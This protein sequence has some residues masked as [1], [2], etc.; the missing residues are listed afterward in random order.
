MREG[1]ATIRECF[2]IRGIHD[3]EI[4]WKE[5][6]NQVNQRLYWFCSVLEIDQV[7]HH[8]Y[9]ARP[10]REEECDSP[11]VALRIESMKLN[12]YETS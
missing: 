2:K 8:F 10:D 3:H 4:A 12:E 7:R 6:F 1:S 5:L 11:D 9:G